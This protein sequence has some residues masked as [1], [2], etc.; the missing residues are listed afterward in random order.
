MDTTPDLTLDEIEAGF[1]RMGVERVSYRKGQVL[2]YERQTPRGYFLPLRGTLR[3]VQDDTPHDV[4]YHPAGAAPRL[5][6]DL[7]ALERPLPYRLEAETDVTLWF[8][9]RFLCQPSSYPM[10]C[11]ENLRKPGNPL[12][13][14]WSHYVTAS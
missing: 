13:Q 3:T 9:S 6:P 2:Q 1:L 4:A 5:F 11:L 12:Y 14:I 7:G 8:F 10:L